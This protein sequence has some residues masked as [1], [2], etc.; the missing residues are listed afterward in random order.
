MSSFFACSIQYIT[1]HS[2]SSSLIV[3][4]YFLSLFIFH[5][6]SLLSPSLLSFNFFF[7]FLF[8][9]S[10][11][12]HRLASNKERS[13]TYFHSPSNY[14]FPRFFRSL[15]LAFFLALSFS[16]LCPPSSAAPYLGDLAFM[17][18]ELSFSRSSGQHYKKCCSFFFVLVV[19]IIISYLVQVY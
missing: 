12:I 14:N 9:F 10:F 8:A 13:L 15:S 7:S 11:H 4:S 6:P 18:T 16:P 5:V 19:T 1:T 2:L 3:H 17:S